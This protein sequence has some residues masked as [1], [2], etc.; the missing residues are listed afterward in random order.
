MQHRFIGHPLGLLSLTAFLLYGSTLQAA[1]EKKLPQEQIALEITQRNTALRTISN[2]FADQQK[3][4]A[5]LRRDQAMLSKN[6]ADPRLS[7]AAR[8]K[9][10]DKMAEVE[11][12]MNTIEIDRTKNRTAFTS[13]A[14]DYEAFAKKYLSEETQMQENSPAN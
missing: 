10:L 13:A 5:L 4:T 7:K 12:E 14:K 9:L 3:K 8:E 11:T 2:E 1:E 6:I